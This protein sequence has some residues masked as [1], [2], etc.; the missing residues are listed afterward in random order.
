MISG[1]RTLSGEAVG[2][3]YLDPTDDGMVPGREECG[4]GRALLS[5]EIP[6]PWALG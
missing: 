5:G 6:N 1:H 4:G 2:C 3:G